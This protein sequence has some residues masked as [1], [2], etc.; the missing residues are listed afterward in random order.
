[1]PSF[2]GADVALAVDPEKESRAI[3]TADISAKR[4]ACSRGDADGYR[5][6]DAR[7]NTHSAT[8]S[9]EKSL[10]CGLERV[11]HLAATKSKP[12]KQLADLVF[13]PL[14]TSEQVTR[15]R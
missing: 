15:I 6:C 13:R 5:R 1:M 12:A 14:R 8:V 11:I 4:R 9:D 7:T 10:C 3:R 2:D